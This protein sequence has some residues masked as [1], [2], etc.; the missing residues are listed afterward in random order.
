VLLLLLDSEDEDDASLDET[1]EGMIGAEE[2]DSLAKNI[3]ISTAVQNKLPM[4]H[5]MVK[6]EDVSQQGSECFFFLAVATS[7]LRSNSMLIYEKNAA[8][9]IHKATLT[10]THML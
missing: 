9:C 5:R 7:R 8:R 2:K 10:Q 1:D 3:Q 6:V 4:S